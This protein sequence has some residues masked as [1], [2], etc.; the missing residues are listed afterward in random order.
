MNAHPRIRITV[1][2]PLTE[3]RELKA[4]SIVLDYQINAIPSATLELAIPGS[5]RQAFLNAREVTA[6]Q[7]GETM[8]IQFDGKTAFA[9]VITEGHLTFSH[10][11]LLKLT[12]R[13]PLI[14][15]DSLRRSR[16]FSQQTDAE[17]LQLLCRAGGRVAIREQMNTK[18]EQKVQYQCSD[19]QM[20][21]HILDRNGL[22]LLPEAGGAVV[23]KP[24]MAEKADHMLS[25]NALTRNTTPLIEE[26][27]VQFSALDQP[28]QLNMTAWDIK[29]QSSLTVT[30]K[31]SELGSGLLGAAQQKKLNKGTW[32][33][34]SST[35]PEQASLEDHANSLLMN[36][37][38]SRVQG[39][40]IVPGSLTYQPGQTLEVTEFGSV[41]NGKGIITSVRHTLNKTRWKTELRLGRSG[42]LSPQSPRIRPEGIHPGV[43]Q[44]FKKDEKNF[45][46]FCVSLPVLGTE[47]NV[48]LARFAVPY[49]SK[50]SGFICYPEPGDEVVVGF[51]DGDP[52]YPVIIGAMYNPK[53]TAP[54][55]EDEA[56][57][58]KG[59]IISQAEESR[60]QLTLNKKDKQILLKTEETDKGI[61]LDTGKEMLMLHEGVTLKADDK[62]QLVLNGKAELKGENVTVQGQSIDLKQ[63]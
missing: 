28:E 59:L 56:N 44:K 6:C 49:A 40:F 23:V 7:P 13:H 58:V 1:G 52:D 3:L 57:A 25:G 41:L 50:N 2:D 27:G 42:L 24:G 20:V 22:W 43:V 8:C 39:K 12:L 9:G 63:G 62:N 26:G 34:N 18:H 10:H 48:L 30:A 35:S 32:Q 36:L 38:L 16:V 11:Q 54:L 21:R 60:L 19:W 33:L 51:F 17:I 31:R 15:L 61:L 5:P 29:S 46:R 4:Q 55:P 37:E 14:A 47:N 53:N 45:G